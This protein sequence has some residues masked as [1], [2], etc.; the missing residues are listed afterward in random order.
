MDGWMDGVS[1]DYSI[2][3]RSVAVAKKADRTEYDVWYNCTRI[4]PKR[5]KCRAWN[6][7]GQVTTMPT[8]I[9]ES[10]ISAVRLSRCS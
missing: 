9:L 2:C 1:V 3:T 8:A 7:H 10:E 5:Q 6:D 4:E